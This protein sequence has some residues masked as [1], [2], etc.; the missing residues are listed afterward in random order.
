MVYHTQN[1][2][3]HAKSKNEALILLALH[4]SRFTL[5]VSLTLLDRLL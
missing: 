2:T 3:R 4:A 5:G 1:I